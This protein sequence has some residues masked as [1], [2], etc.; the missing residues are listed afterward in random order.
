MPVTDVEL[1]RVLNAL[2]VTLTDQKVERFDPERF[3]Q[4]VTGALAGQTGLKVV[5]EPGSGGRAARLEEDGRPVALVRLEGSRWETE[6]RRP[7]LDT[8]AYIPTPG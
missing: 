1:D 6:R 3:Q 7:T 5:E 2:Q 4:I 8:R